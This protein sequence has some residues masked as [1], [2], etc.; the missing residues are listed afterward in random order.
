MNA[1][2]TEAPPP[3]RAWRL[4]AVPCPAFSAAYPTNSPHVVPTSSRPSRHRRPQI[5]CVAP[6][7][8][9]QWTTISVVAAVSGVFV[10]KSVWPAVRDSAPGSTG[11]S[12]VLATFAAQLAFGL[13]LKVYFFG[14]AAS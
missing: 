3:M 5:L 10:I 7:P 14:A 13:L 6:S 8:A 9:L 2:T 11:R 12:L 4:A 1:V